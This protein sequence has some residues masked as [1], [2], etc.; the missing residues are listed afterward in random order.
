MPLLLGCF[1]HLVGL[2]GTS[3]CVSSLT[4]TCPYLYPRSSSVH[5]KQL[6]CRVAPREPA[7]PAS[8]RQPRL[9]HLLQQQFHLIEGAL[10]AP[11]APWRPVAPRSAG[12]RR[13]C[14]AQKE[15]EPKNRKVRKI[16]QQQHQ[17][18]QPHMAQRSGIMALGWALDEVV[19]DQKQQHFSRSLPIV[20]TPD[21]LE[22]ASLRAPQ[23]RRGSA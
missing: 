23:D 15:S 9:V 19:Q 16:D 7:R 5:I 12:T 13:R 18:P 22:L 3:A 14:V 8:G 17:Q 11:V 10:L 4:C 2:V 21:L 6:G 1:W 20:A